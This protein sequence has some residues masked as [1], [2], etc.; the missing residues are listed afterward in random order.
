MDLCPQIPSECPP[1]RTLKE[2]EVP[3]S[4]SGGARCFCKVCVLSKKGILASLLA[5]AFTMCVTVSTAL[6]VGLEIITICY[7]FFP[8]DR[9]L[10]MLSL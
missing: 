8:N 5:S 4:Q 7:Q 2:E 9:I 1:G 6:Y 10:V 3:A